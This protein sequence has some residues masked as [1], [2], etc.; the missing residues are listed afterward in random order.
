MYGLYDTDGI[1]RFVGGDREACDAYAK[2][3]D[4]ASLECCLMAL[5]E[6]N[7]IAVKGQQKVRQ[8]MNSN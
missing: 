3:C 2:L 4:M 8:A 1:P 5:A 6:P 7:A